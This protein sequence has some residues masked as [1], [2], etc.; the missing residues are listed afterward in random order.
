MEKIYIVEQEMTSYN[1]DSLH[2][3]A[4]SFVYEMRIDLEGPYSQT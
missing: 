3:L 2:F 4:S 1:L